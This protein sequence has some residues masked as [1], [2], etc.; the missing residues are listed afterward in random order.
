MMI[1]H[2][3]LT[4]IRS[5]R[6]HQAMNLH[7]NMTHLQWAV[8]TYVRDYIG[9][10]GVSP[11]YQEITDTIGLS[12]KSHAHKIVQKLCKLEMLNTHSNMQRNIT[13]GSPNDK[14]ER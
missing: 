8:Y 3:N 12:S 6:S 14:Q 9:M 2:H 13:I 4:R 1:L 5:E 10:H 11:T 7:S